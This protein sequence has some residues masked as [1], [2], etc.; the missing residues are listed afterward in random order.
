MHT[1]T[2]S[3]RAHVTYSFK[4]SGT[5]IPPHQISDSGGLNEIVT[6]QART[7]DI[8]YISFLEEEEQ[9]ENNTIITTLKTQKNKNKN[10][11][12]N[13]NSD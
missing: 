3:I 10:N 1:R 13:N 6:R 12:N 5:R 9:M 2:H 4:E 7:G 11:N 8:V